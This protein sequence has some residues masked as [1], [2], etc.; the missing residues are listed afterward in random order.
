MNSQSLPNDM[1]LKDIAV[2]IAPN[3]II[4]MKFWKNC[5]FFT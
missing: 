4:V 1:M 5:F 2:P 3:N